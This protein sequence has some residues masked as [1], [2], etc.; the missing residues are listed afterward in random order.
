MN[1]DKALHAA[2]DVAAVRGSA[3]ATGRNLEAVDDVTVQLLGNASKSQ[4]DQFGPTPSCSDTF[5]WRLVHALGFMIGGTTFIAGTACYYWPSSDS[6]S[7]LAAVLYTVGSVGF[8]SVDVLEFIT[9]LSCPL[10][11]NISLSAIG[12][13]LYVVGSIGFLPSIMNTTEDVGVWG[14]IGGSAFIG[15]S[16][17]WKLIRIGTPVVTTSEGDGEE[18]VS[19]GSPSIRTLVASVD[20]FTAA[21]V[22][23]GACLGAWAFFVGTCMYDYS[24][25][26]QLFGIQWMNA[27]LDIWMAGSI[28]F[29]IGAFFLSY[30]HFVLRIT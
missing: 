4:N 15:C 19:D 13:T 30:R 17:V 9:F 18:I 20:S 3:K 28:F 26:E 22:E 21:G 1:F 7:A 5:L 25:A 29:T 11:A 6:L 23:G 10:R 27:I 16:Q 14:F 2:D 12:S 8:L 24:T